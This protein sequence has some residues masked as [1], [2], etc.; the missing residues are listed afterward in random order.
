MN[1]SAVVLPNQS[2]PPAA[3]VQPKYGV[4]NKQAQTVNEE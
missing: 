1:L 3:T 2:R 4:K